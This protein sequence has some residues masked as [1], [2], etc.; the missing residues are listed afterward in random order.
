MTEIVN[1]FL[2]S[3]A[4][5]NGQIDQSLSFV[6]LL[7]YYLTN[8]ELNEPFSIVEIGVWFL[9]HFELARNLDY[10]YMDLCGTH[11]YLIVSSVIST[12]NHDPS[13]QQNVL[14]L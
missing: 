12:C 10:P 1:P 6:A 4:P 11:L 5:N 7:N 2:H 13:H 9:F 8:F 14:W 3:F